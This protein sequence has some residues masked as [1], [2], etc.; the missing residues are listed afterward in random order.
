MTTLTIVMATSTGDE[1]ECVIRAGRDLGYASMKDE[2]VDLAVAI[3]KGR[4]AFGVL[5]TG[6]GKSLCYSCL[7]GAFDYFLGNC[8]Q[9]QDSIVLVITPLL[10]IMKDQVYHCSI[11]RVNSTLILM[12][13]I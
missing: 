13:K 5:P 7:P 10:A 11:S 4:D 12:Y 2:Q 6:F 9:A 3:M 8:S 1:R